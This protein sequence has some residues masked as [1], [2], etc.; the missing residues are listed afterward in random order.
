[1]VGSLTSVQVSSITY[2]Q[3]TGHHRRVWS[4]VTAVCWTRGRGDWHVMSD[5]LMPGPKHIFMQ[6]DTVAG[7]KNTGTQQSFHIP[8]IALLSVICHAILM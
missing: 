3:D 1:M 6:S 8:H 2:P 7:D 4:L 5:C